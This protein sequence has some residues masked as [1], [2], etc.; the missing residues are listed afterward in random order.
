M[1]IRLHLR[2]MRVL[3]VVADE[4]GRLVVAMIATTLR[5]QCR[6]RTWAFPSARSRR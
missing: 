1:M 2:A 5:L 6:F 4:P 3:E